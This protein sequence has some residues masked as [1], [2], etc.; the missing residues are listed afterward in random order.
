MRKSNVDFSTPQRQS[1][2]AI[3][4]I[5]FK[6]FKIIVRQ[7]IPAIAVIFLGKKDGRGDYLLYVIVGI[8]L[9]TMIFSILNYFKTYFLVSGDEL[10]LHTGVINR[11][12]ISIPFSK[13]QTID[14]EQNIL[15]RILEVTKIKVDTA[16]G[17]KKEF[18][19][20]A[21]GLDVASA[22]REI[23]TTTQSPHESQEVETTEKA[24]I[25]T[26]KIFQI[27]LPLL[28]KIGL[29]ENHLR[30]GGLIF[31][32]GFWIYHNLKEVG[33]DIDETYE[34][35]D[36]DIFSFDVVIYFLIAFV[37]ISIV[38]SLGRVLLRYYDL[39]FVRRDHGF[40]IEYGLFNRKTVSA[41][42]N[43]IQSISWQQNYLQKSIGLHELFLN[44][45]ASKEIK[46]K[47]KIGIPGLNAHHIEDIKEVLYPTLDLSSKIFKSI[48]YKYFTRNAN[49][50]L[51]IVTILAAIAFV[52]KSY[53][54]VIGISVVSSLLLYNL[55]R[56]FRK[57]AYT[58][59]DEIIAVRGGV[60]GK[61][62]VLMPT[63]KLQS[64]HL[65][66]SPCQ[67][68]HQLC[69]ISMVSAAGVIDIPFIPISE[70]HNIVDRCIYTIEIVRKEW[71]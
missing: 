3:V 19:L 42:D 4:F 16:G 67:R 2:W 17:E 48:D 39:S 6:T 27:D 35:V 49:I 50:L 70:G 38:I 30:S 12:K 64:I 25:P 44:Q 51:I 40:K 26:R 14:T 68:R 53:Y 52:L 34:D 32:A 11:K 55:H 21:V 62:T 9:L 69:T 57:T 43:R 65:H 18:D 46:E 63:Y 23:V 61:K 56:K 71:M 24:A 60:Y 66:Q 59:D 47:E 8:A 7:A 20:S 1:Y 22:L 28:W 36:R 37:L 33:V 45:V 29:T 58:Y 10:I 41:L 54:I 13:I 15:H 5:I 31:A